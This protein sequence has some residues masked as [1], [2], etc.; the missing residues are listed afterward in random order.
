M[1]RRGAPYH[2]APKVLITDHPWPDISVEQAVFSQAKLTLICGP[3][4]AGS[5]EDVERL[6]RQHNPRAILACWAP[7]SENAIAAPSDLAVVS[8]LGVGLDNIAV[9]AATARGTWV[10]NVP[11]Y[12]VA[13]VSD[14]A[15]AMLLAYTRG[16]ARLSSEVKI[17]GWRRDGSDLLRM[18]D[19]TVAIW[20]YGRIGRETAR[21]LIPFGCRIITYS[22]PAPVVEAPVE[23]VAL[24]EIQAHADVIILHIPLTPASA[25]IVDARFL[26]LCRKRPFLINVSRGELVDNTA[27]LSAL[28]NGQI[29]GAALDVVDGEPSPP[30]E[31]LRDRNVIVTPH[32]ANSSTSALIDLRRRACEEVVRVLNGDPPV[33]PCN[34][35]ILDRP[36]DGGVASD[37]R[38]IT[39]SHG[40]EVIK[41]ALP[42]LKV[43]AEWFSDPARSDIEV[44]A[45]RAAAEL[46][47][48]C[49]VPQILWAKPDEHTFAMRLVDRRLSNWKTQLLAGRIDVRTAARAGELLGQ[50]H[51]RSAPRND[52][53]RRFEDTTYFEELRIEPFFHRVAAKSGELGGQIRSIAA[54]MQ[55]RRS[56]LV[57]G[58]YSPKNLLADGRDIVVLDFEVAHW[59]DPR[60]DVGFCLSHLLLKT[61]RREAIKTQM[62]SAINHFVSAYKA[63]GPA[64]VDQHLEE[65]VGCL[66][67][68]RLD[69]ASPVDYLSDMDVASTRAVAAAMITSQGGSIEALFPGI[70]L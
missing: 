66:M 41:R 33:H 60:F 8:R 19:L 40:P 31:L 28:Q 14:H 54:G 70:A 44:A 58:D 23:A 67:L 53:R 16:V 62:L 18:S 17:N 21:K 56:A 20:G 47:G 27:L 42:K 51:T 10:T 36:L 38:V 45:I 15:I 50:L 57:H 52:I 6:V 68:A 32:V 13:E 59:G 43:A 49:N 61:Q 63:T 5:A 48:P 35:P 34:A 46:I 1:Q 65:I 4:V 22:Q 30:I 26:T 9:A 12:C 3:A 37:I 39:G 55:S 2:S 25:K 11:D 69:G 29:R 7:V 64:I 24:A